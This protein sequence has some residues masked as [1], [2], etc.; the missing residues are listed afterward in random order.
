LEELL[1]E[2]QKFYVRQ[3]EGKQKLKA[4]VMLSTIGQIIQEKNTF[5][6]VGPRPA[7]KPQKGRPTSQASGGGGEK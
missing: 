6:R 2:N 3:D 7:Q 4:K 1:R 5:P